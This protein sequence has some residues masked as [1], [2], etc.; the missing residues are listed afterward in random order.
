MAVPEPLV[1][2]AE[3][4]ESAGFAPPLGANSVVVKLAE[5]LKLVAMLLSEILAGFVVGSLSLNPSAIPSLLVSSLCC[6]RIPSKLKLKLTPAVK[7]AAPVLFV[8]ALLPVIAGIRKA[9]GLTTYWFDE[10]VMY[11]PDGL[12]LESGIL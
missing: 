5:A 6:Q 7:E 4:E 9:R 8:A 10:P 2:E 12:P 3:A 11:S 1:M